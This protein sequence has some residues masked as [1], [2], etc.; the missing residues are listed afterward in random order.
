MNKLRLSYTF[1][2]LWSMG[3]TD[4][5][6]DMYFKRRVL[7]TPQIEAGRKF[8]KDLESKILTDK[9]VKLGNTNI[10]FSAPQVEVKY[11]VTLDDRFTLTGV[12]DCIDGTTI[13]EWKTGVQTSED[14]AR[15]YQLGTYFLLMELSSQTVNSGIIGHF[16][17]YEKQCDISIVHNSKA[18]K[19]KTLDFIY[20]V[21]G[22]IYNF[23]EENIWKKKE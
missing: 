16:N 21:G 13:Y 11:N 18:I 23:F 19:E 3:R 2:N 12:I 1:L 15:G 5:A 7:D 22:D 20:G 8:H 9:C 17:Q 6:L 4:D 14:Y 10:S